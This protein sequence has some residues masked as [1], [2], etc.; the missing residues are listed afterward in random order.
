[1]INEICNYR[2]SFSLNS[3]HHCSWERS[4]FNYVEV[5]LCSKAKHVHFGWLDVLSNW[6]TFTHG[7]T[8]LLLRTW[9]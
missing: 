8:L 7:C 5:K 2:L 4:R 1:M 3:L 9:I 6:L